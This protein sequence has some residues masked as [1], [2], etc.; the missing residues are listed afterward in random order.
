VWYLGWLKAYSFYDRGTSNP[1]KSGTD[2]PLRTGTLI[3]HRSVPLKEKNTDI[4]F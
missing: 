2:I 3:K 1:L 4:P